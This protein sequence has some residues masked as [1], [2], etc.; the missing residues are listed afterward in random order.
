MDEPFRDNNFWVKA[1]TPQAGVL[2]CYN[3]V[4]LLDR[5]QVAAGELRCV[6]GPWKWAVYDASNTRYYGEWTGYK[7]RKAAVKAFVD[8]ALLRPRFHGNELVADTI[9][10]AALRERQAYFA[11]VR[12][13]K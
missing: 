10:E 5:R 6:K 7:T 1:G 13:E 4:V 12:D 11:S 3:Q 8:L 9:V 2:A